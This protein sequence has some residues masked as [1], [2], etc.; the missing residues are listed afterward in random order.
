M[1]KFKKI[2]GIKLNMPSESVFT[3]Y[4]PLDNVKDITLLQKD[5]YYVPESFKN[6]IDNLLNNYRLIGVPEGGN[7]TKRKIYK[8]R[9]SKKK[10]LI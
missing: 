8:R 1:G 9:N 6:F 3:G 4:P 2:N 5:P 7:K 10:C